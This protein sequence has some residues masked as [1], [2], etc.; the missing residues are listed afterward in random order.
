MNGVT[1]AP[2]PPSSSKPRARMCRRPSFSFAVVTALLCW[3]NAAPAQEEP[4]PNNS[5]TKTQPARDPA[6]IRALARIWSLCPPPDADEV[7][8]RVVSVEGVV[9]PYTAELVWR[10]ESAR[11][12]LVQDVPTEGA[13]KLASVVRGCLLP[14]F[15]ARMSWQPQSAA[16][17]E[18]TAER[19]GGALVVTQREKSTAPGLPP[20]NQST[21]HES[22]TADGLASPVSC[23]IR[24]TTPVPL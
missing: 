14:P 21:R 12:R 17:N 5:A 2:G 7:R 20:V 10:V 18:V 23:D 16:R 22:L 6:G 19:T 15:V 9:F 11:P 1:D 13:R 3:T 24:S 4:P 8:A